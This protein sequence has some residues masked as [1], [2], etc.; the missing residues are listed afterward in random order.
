MSNHSTFVSNRTRIDETSQKHVR[1]YVTYGHLREKNK[2]CGRVREAEEKVKDKN[3]TFRNTLANAAK[4]K[5]F[6]LAC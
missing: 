5:K 2:K 6:V 1:L 4:N 3:I